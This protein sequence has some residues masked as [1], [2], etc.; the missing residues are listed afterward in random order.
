MSAL[1]ATAIAT[2][3]GTKTFDVLFGEVVKKIFSKQEEPA[4]GKLRTA[5]LKEHCERTY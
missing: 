3:I 1:A 2:H 4:P 5:H